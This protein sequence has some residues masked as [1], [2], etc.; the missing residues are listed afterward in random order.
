MVNSEPDDCKI[1][2]PARYDSS[3]FPGKILTPLLGRPMLLHVYQ[4]AQEAGL[5]EALVA[6]DD[7]RIADLCEQHGIRRV[8]TSPLHQ[9]GTDRVA[10][11]V[12]DQR[13]P[14]DTRV[15]CLQGDEP[16]TPPQVIRQVADNLVVHPEAAIATLCAPVQDEEEYRNPDR[17][18]VVFDD[19]GRALYFSRASI[20]A[21][22][23]DVDTDRPFPQSWVHIGMYAYRADFLLRWQ[24]LAPHPYEQ[25]ERLEQLRALANGCMIHVEAAQVIPAHGVDRAEDVDS[26]EAILKR[27]YPT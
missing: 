7:R 11:V 8:M 23:A 4:R 21:R 1:V 22:R 25:E 26:I 6:T 15:V 18:K 10:E 19:N 12:A 3:R 5:G 2:I 20:P 24:S 27:Q 17:V 13:W 9:S 16:A 14:A